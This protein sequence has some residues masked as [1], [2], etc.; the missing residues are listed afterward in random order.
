MCKFFF[1]SSH[2][3]LKCVKGCYIGENIRILLDTIEYTTGKIDPGLIA[4]LDFEKAFDSVSWTFLV[5]TL[6]V[7]NFGENFIKWI[8][9]LYNKP[10]CAVTNN[11]YSSDLWKISRG[12]RQGCPIAAFLFIIVAEIM[13][14]NIKNE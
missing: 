8:E 14:V 10:N 7:F 9:I 13:A 4:F 3:L 12:L 11:G 5:K 6:K 2:I 1:S